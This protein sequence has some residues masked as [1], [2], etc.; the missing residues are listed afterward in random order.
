MT[1]TVYAGVAP[2]VPPELNGVTQ[3]ACVKFRDEL[4]A[5]RM[6]LDNI[7]GLHRHVS[8]VSMI[9]LTLPS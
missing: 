7:E 2:I 8:I 4:L 1:N 9:Q 3:A 6:M 5:Y